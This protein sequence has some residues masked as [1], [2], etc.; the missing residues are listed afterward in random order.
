MS[1][2]Q[3]TAHKKFSRLSGA[4]KTAILFLCL[5]EE[6][7]SQI[8]QKMEAHEIS[9]ITRAVTQLGEVQAEIV[10]EVMEEF[11]TRLSNYS[12]VTGSADSARDLLKGFLPDEK[13][14]EL[15]EDSGDKSTEDLWRQIS[16]LDEVFLFDYLAGE[17]LQTVAVILGHI[18][19]EKTAKILPLLGSEK[20]VQLVERMLNADDPPRKV[21]RAVEDS[22]RRDVLARAG[23][24][25]T[26]ER[27]KK[28]VKVFNNLDSEVFKGMSRKLEESAPEKIKAI[29]QKM[30]VFDD[31]T[32]LP[33][34]SVA[35]IMR[36]VPSTSLP[37]ALRGAS[38]EQRELFLAAL[39]SRP[40]EMLREE[41]NSLGPVRSRDVKT[42]QSEMVSV[43]MD[44]IEVGDVELP[45]SDDEEMI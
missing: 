27:E 2:N 35:Q 42:A 36:G 8:M 3:L 43:A 45:S 40:R 28:L 25:S 29:R 21:M 22:L 24:D 14:D 18:R 17:H 7:G 15:L 34:A 20:S 39:P 6:K 5:G 30:F 44:L 23:R 4:E 33:P 11:G 16:D 41:M 31:I 38:K 13:I 9:K 1:L 37:L 19:P 26:D 10:E 32:A 12:G